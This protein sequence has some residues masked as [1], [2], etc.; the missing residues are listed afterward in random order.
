MTST[1]LQL[2]S[3]LGYIKTLLFDF[4]ND[5]TDWR[6][7][8][9]FWLGTRF[10]LSPNILKVIQCWKH[11]F[12]SLIHDVGIIIL[13]TSFHMICQMTSKL[14]VC[15]KCFHTILNISIVDTR[16]PTS[17]TNGEKCNEC[18][19]PDGGR[20]LAMDET[21]DCFLLCLICSQLFLLVRTLDIVLVACSQS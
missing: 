12:V 1:V 2:V 8:P 19:N 6:I 13:W 4:G 17:W 18:N 5:V 21:H 10:P 7:T 14:C 11:T 15:S 9:Y 20:D 16:L 3:S